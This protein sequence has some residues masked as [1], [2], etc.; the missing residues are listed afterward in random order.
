MNTFVNVLEKHN[1]E[2]CLRRGHLRI[3]QVNLGNLCNQNCQHC[4]INASPQGENMMS[5]KV[6]DDV[7]GFLAGYKITTL[8]ITGG[9]PELNPH[10]EYLVKKARLL[11]DELIVR[12]NLSVLFE[13]GKGH[14]PE[15][16]K[17]NQVHLICS[18]PCYLKENVDR[19][20][21]SG[22]F[23]KSLKALKVLN[24]LGF[25]KDKELKL[26]LVYNPQGPNLPPDQAELEKDYKQKL[27]QDYDLSF[28]RLITITNVPIKKFKT[29]LESQGIYEKYYELLKNNF[30]PEVL[31]SLMCHTFLSVGF[32]GRLYD[33]D[34]NQAL[35]LAIKTENNNILTIDRLDPQRL[36][37]KEILIGEHC[38]SCTAGSGSGC[39][40]ALTEDKRE[41]VK[42]YYRKDIQ[43]KKDLKTSACCLSE[44]SPR[45]HKE[46]LAKLEPEI[47]EKFYGC[48]SPIPPALEGI[49]VL[50]LGC[51]T[52]RDVYLAS[53]LVGEKGEVIGIDM[54]DEQLAVAR[55]HLDSQMKR[56]GFKTRNVDF[57]K[58][59]IEDLKTA[60]INDNSI[61][62]VISNCV[63][64][65]S[66]DKEKVF[67]E[68]FRVL[69]PGGELYFSDVFSG[70]RI[71]KQLRADPVLYGECLAGAI[72][73]ED[74]RRLLGSLGCLDYRV[75]NKRRLTIDNPE[76]KQKIGLIDFYSLTIRAF[77]LADLEDRCEDYGQLARY[78]GTIAEMPNK[79]I[80]DDQHTFI[81]GKTELV[82]GNTASMLS[83]TRYRKHFELSGDRKVHYGLFACAPIHG[84]SKSNDSSSQG[85]C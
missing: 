27:K 85:C 3:L 59:Y 37:G 26:D 45:E 49:K 5:K 47:L 66:P 43:N 67:S 73:L 28:N 65:L 46:I 8:D 64:N 18:M 61:D 14:L 63:I 9:A 24:Q 69:K 23:D 76:L 32:D 71:A 79:F 6:I 44:A 30:N 55:K 15:F 56:F 68:I 20:R 70:Q 38:L 41:A 58:G 17:D 11:V 40:G 39:Q 48:G 12:S 4:H 82:C 35:S 53:K 51:G 29:Y 54:T 36:E 10:F 2:T 84:K 13:P 19:Q 33:C 22:T 60:G 52:G 80:L 1:V 21:G 25:S 83:Q 7:L 31:E 16:F 78:L 50:D 62:L 72:Y 42:D 75:V 81:I 34:F 74:F 77:K 57:R